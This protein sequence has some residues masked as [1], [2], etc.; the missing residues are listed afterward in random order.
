MT[1]S[2]PLRWSP[3]W[4]QGIRLYQPH[5]E[6]IEFLARHPDVLIT[7]VEIARDE[8]MADIAQVEA[9]LDRT[10]GH[11]IQRW[12]GK[13]RQRRW[14]N[15]NWRSGDLAKDKRRLLGTVFQDGDR[16]SKVT[17]ELTAVT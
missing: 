10:Y 6:A 1:I 16:P 12:H 9:R 4:R 15:G 17:G 14:A 11:F 13:R 2:R 8:I 7:Y 3:R 5:R